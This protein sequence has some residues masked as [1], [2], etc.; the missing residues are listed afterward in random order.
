MGCCKPGRR[1]PRQRSRVTDADAALF[2]AFLLRGPLSVAEWC[3]DGHLPAGTNLLLLVDQFEE[4]FRYQDYAGREEAEAFAALL[5]ESARQSRV[6]IYVTLTMRSEY[7]GACALIDGLAEAISAGMVLI[8]RMTRE[9]CRSAI[10][11]PAA[12]CGFKIADD[13]T[14]RLL[15]DLAAFAPWDDRSTR[16][17]LDRLGAPRRPAAAVAILPQPHVDAGP[18]TRSWT[19]RS[20]S[21]LA[22]YERIGGLS[23]ALNAHA[24]EVLSRPRRGLPPGSR[25]GIPGAHRRIGWR[26]KRCGGRRASTNWWQIC[27]GDEARARKV[28]DAFRAPGCNFLAPG[29]DPANPRPLTADTIVDISHESLIR[30]WRAIVGVGRS[31]RACSP[32]MAAPAGSLRRQAAAARA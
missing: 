20:C 30:Q 7:L 18:A 14:N 31:G 10:V 6:P 22:D 12:V 11:G 28:V 32:A 24:D 26:A 1:G 2:R 3:A 23:G 19:R 13:L 16:D 5:L 4:L 15:N 9:Q 17:Q 27:G 29:F 8:P 21:R 25:G